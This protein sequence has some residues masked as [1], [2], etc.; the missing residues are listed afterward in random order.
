MQA[1]LNSSILTAGIKDADI[2]KLAKIK[3]TSLFLLGGFMVMFITLIFRLFHNPIMSFVMIDICTSLGFLLTYLCLRKYQN[4][5]YIVLFS[6]V[7]IITFML[8]FI[9]INH[10]ISFGLVWSYTIT[11]FVIPLVGFKKGSIFLAVFYACIFGFMHFEFEI[12][13][14]SGW[15]KLS[16]M[17]YIS[18][19]ISLFLL[20][21]FYDLVFE[22]FQNELYKMSTIDELTK[23]YNRRKINR[24]IIDQIN[25]AK[26][27]KNDDLKL[28][29]CVFDID[30]F[31]LINDNFGHI[32]GDRVLKDVAKISK[33]S[34]RVVDFIGRWGGEEFCVI[35]PNVEVK[36][37][38][39]I[40]EKIRQNIKNFDFNINK[41]IT[42]SYGVSVYNE[43]NDDNLSFI[44]RADE[45]MYWA[46][47]N[48]KDRI[49]IS[50]E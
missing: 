5:E 7:F 18:V 12:W 47:K 21:S 10:N 41:T 26:R 36:H 19:S 38:L 46:K 13:T 30:D 28:A 27:Q 11:L 35:V 2:H 9:K 32:I 40:V 20:G 16:L 42:C 25:I 3:L 45:A 23:I 24:I 39:R 34:L 15:D 17:R 49:K 44:Q 22:N 1:F 43:D 48:G 37:M 8:I 4:L 33:E 14:Q 50:N 6:V 31:K 29:V